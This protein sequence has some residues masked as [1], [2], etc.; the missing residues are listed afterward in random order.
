MADEL[1]RA[2]RINEERLMKHTD[3]TLKA[4]RM[5]IGLRL[6]KCSGKYIVTLLTVDTYTVYIDDMTERCIMCGGSEDSMLHPDYTDWVRMTIIAIAVWCNASWQ[7]FIIM[8]IT[9]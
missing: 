5:E 1:L 9:P 8:A 7:V 6:L 2:G 3:Q 4:A